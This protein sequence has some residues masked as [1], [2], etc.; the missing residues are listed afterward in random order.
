MAISDDFKGRTNAYLHMFK[1]KKM[2]PKIYEEREGVKLWDRTM[3]LWKKIDPDTV[4][5]KI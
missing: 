5:L 2:D 3:D 4:S 1:A